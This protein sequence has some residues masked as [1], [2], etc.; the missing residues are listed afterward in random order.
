M[1][2]VYSKPLVLLTWYNLEGW[3]ALKDNQ[4]HAS[5]TKSGLLTLLVEPVRLGEKKWFVTFSE[6]PELCSELC[7]DEK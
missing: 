6:L 1:G 2:G 5:T 7:L 3:H 4:I